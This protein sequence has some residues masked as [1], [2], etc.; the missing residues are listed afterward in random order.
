MKDIFEHPWMKIDVPKIPLN[1][2]F[3][4]MASFTKY[5]KV[6]LSIIKLKKLS[7]IYIASQF[8]EK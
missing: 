3:H 1:I 8:S 2:N 6:K 4:K 5:S 7:A